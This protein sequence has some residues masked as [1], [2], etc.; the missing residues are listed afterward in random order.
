MMA[1]SVSREL[2]IAQPD[3]YGSPEY[4]IAYGVDALDERRLVAIAQ[5]FDRRGRGLHKLGDQVGQ[6][7][8]GGDQEVAAAHGGVEHLQVQYGFGRVE[9]SQFR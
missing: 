4:V 7:V 2:S 3:S 6:D 1:R 9:L 5:P 8:H